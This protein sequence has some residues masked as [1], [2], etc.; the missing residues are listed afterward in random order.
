LSRVQRKP[1]KSQISKRPDRH[2]GS[3][4]KDEVERLNELKAKALATRKNDRPDVDSTIEL[5]YLRI[6]GRVKD[7]GPVEA[8]LKQLKVALNQA[9]S[10]MNKIMDEAERQR[11]SK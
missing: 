4:K 6:L 3:L 5:M 2:A 9:T 11:A 7:R 8:E 10:L 1:T